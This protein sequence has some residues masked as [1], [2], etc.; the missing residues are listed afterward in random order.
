MALPPGDL[1][2]VQ[3]LLPGMGQGWGVPANCIFLLMEKAHFQMFSRFA[4]TGSSL[5]SAENDVEI[6]CLLAWCVG[7]AIES[8]LS[9]EADLSWLAWSSPNTIFW[10]EACLG[11]RISRYLLFAELQLFPNKADYNTS[12]GWRGYELMLGLGRGGSGTLHHLCI[13]WG[14]SNFS[15]PPILSFPIPSSLPLPVAVSLNFYY[16][17]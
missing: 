13:S 15:T 10:V 5:I 6:H 8:L 4:F 14:D 1:N 11:E 16:F 17:L 7:R 12:W 3:T 9:S 2:A